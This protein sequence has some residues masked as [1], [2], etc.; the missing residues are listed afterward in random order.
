MEIQLPVDNKTILKLV[1]RNAEIVCPTNGYNRKNINAVDAFK[2][3]NEYWS[4]LPMPVQD[5]Y[6]SL[7]E[8]TVSIIGEASEYLVVK[9]KLTDVVTR[10]FK[11][12]DYEHLTWWTLTHGRVAYNKDMTETVPERYSE[13]LTYT[14]S[15]YNGL[16][17]LSMFFKMLSPIWSLFS[18]TPNTLDIGFKEINALELMDDSGIYKLPAMERLADYCAALAEKVAPTLSSAII[19]KYIGTNEIPKYFLALAIVRRISIGEIRSQHDTLIKI[20]CNFLQSIIKN[21]AGGVRDKG[22][23]KSDSDDPDSVAERYRISQE[24]PDY[25]IV[26]EES[27]ISDIPRAVKEVHPDGNVQKVLT[28]IKNINDNLRFSISEYHVPLVCLVCFKIT[29]PRSFILMSREARLNLIGIA[30]GRLSDMGYQEVANLLISTHEEKDPDDMDMHSVSGFA[31][32]T[33]TKE[34]KEKLEAIYPNQQHETQIKN[35]SNPGLLMI[36]T[37]IDEINNY[38]WDENLVLPQNL[39]NIIATLILEREVHYV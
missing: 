6:F 27:A 29:N 38:N 12:V 11:L 22:K 17:V 19:S 15:D 24:I 23:F 37:V 10:L 26:T 4:T 13:R 30:A 1:H 36:E 21:L 8:E 3:L 9:K 28:Y 35:K 14:I 18:D 34:N 5:A 25:V 31:F 39:R 33:T 32:T 20:A 2:P 16:V 7:Y